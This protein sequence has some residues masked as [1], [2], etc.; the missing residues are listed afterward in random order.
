MLV[1]FLET[2]FRGLGGFSSHGHD[3]NNFGI[4]ILT[5]IG[6]ISHRKIYLLHNF[7]VFLRLY[8]LASTHS[9]VL[10]SIPEYLVN[11]I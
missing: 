1:I 5:G 9:P 7:G 3:M 2:L 6:V 10:H 8:V 11:D 4:N